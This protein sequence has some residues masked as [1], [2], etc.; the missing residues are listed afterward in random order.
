MQSGAEDYKKYL[1]D[2]NVHVF[3]D[4]VMKHGREGRVHIIVTIS[5]P[6]R[7]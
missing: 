2:N 1:L 6:E 3:Y 7:S 5:K 4:I